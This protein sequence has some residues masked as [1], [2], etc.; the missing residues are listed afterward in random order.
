MYDWRYH[1]FVTH[2]TFPSCCCVCALNDAH[3]TVSLAPTASTLP[4]LLL[5]HQC[6]YSR[7]SWLATFA[8]PC[9]SRKL[10]Q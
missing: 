8:W 4:Q 2:W 7:I 9:G 5:L 10:R 3:Y 6:T 1:A